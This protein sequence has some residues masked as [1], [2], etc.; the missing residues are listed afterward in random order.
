[1]RILRL[2][3]TTPRKYCRLLVSRRLWLHLLSLICAIATVSKSGKLGSKFKK[4]HLW[5]KGHPLIWE[6]VNSCLWLICYM[7]SCCHRGMMLGLL[8]VNSLGNI[9]H[10]ITPTSK[11]AIRESLKPVT[12]CRNLEHSKTSMMNNIEMIL[13]NYLCLKWTKIAR[14]CNLRIQGSITQQ[15]LLMIKTIPLLSMW[16]G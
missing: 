11:V 6:M 3:I 1:M 16:P 12:E 13:S 4:K 5:W 8:S 2:S 14:K 15:A 9:S 10:S 7:V